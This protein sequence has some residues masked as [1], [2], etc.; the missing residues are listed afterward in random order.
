MYTAARG[1][2]DLG[3][4]VRLEYLGNLRNPLGLVAARRRVAKIAAEFDVVHAQYGSACS[5]ATSGCGRPSVVS[6]RGNDWN[7]HSASVHPLWL[8]TR[9]ARGMTM[10]ALRGFRAVVC[11][12]HRIAQEVSRHCRIDTEVLVLPSAIDLSLWPETL[13]ERQERQ[14]TH[15][16]LF[17]S[18]NTSDPI[19]RQWLLE[20]AVAI[21]SARIGRIE[22]VRA[23]GI[24]HHEMPALVASCDAVACTS[25]T[26]GWPNSVKEALAC[27]IPFVSTDVGDLRVIANSEQSCRIVE[28]NPEAVARGLCE[29]LAAGR[30]PNLRRHVLHMGLEPASRSLL[31]LYERLA[32]Y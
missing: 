10:S 13:P 4:D 24:P 14:Y 7:L 3:V 6:L 22:V 5:V 18:N 12:S 1:L 30:D 20:R 11:V 8:H 17:T 21:A 28:P 31:T 9:I 25:E 26:E 2:M 19:K 32:A 23:T 29:V 15:R 27:G 16:V